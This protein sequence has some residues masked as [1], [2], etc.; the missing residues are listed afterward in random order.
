[1]SDDLTAL[2]PGGQL[3]AHVM[4]FGRLLRQLGLAV[5]PERSLAALRAMAMI[6]ITRRADF[7]WTLHAVWVHREEH[8]ALF[9]LAFRRFWQDPERAVL[10]PMLADLLSQSRVPST[11]EQRPGERRL[12]EARD[13]TQPETS[14]P[15]SPLHELAAH[16]SWSRRELLRRKDFEQMSAHEVAQAKAMVSRLRPPWRQLSTR[17]MRPVAGGRRADLRA[18]IRAS[19][20]GG[21]DHIPLRWRA[22]RHRPP[23]LVVL[24]DISGSMSTYSRMLLHFAHALSSDRDRVHTFVFATRLTNVTRTLR[25][26]DIDAALA[27]LG[28]DVPD[29]DGGTRIA[30]CLR[31]FNY[32]WSRRVLAQGAV[33]LLITDGLDRDDGE[34]LQHE[35]SRLR[36][37]CR[38]LVW[39]NP[40]LRYE[41]FEP[42]A[43]GIRAMLPHVDEMRAAHH[44]A[45]L[46]D[47]GEAL[48]RPANRFLTRTHPASRS[49]AS[50]EPRL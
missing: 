32:R 29:W 50:A 3:P 43:A 41:A 17:R 13:A 9:D 36:R 34:G 12:A 47:L 26:R 15:E 46:E 45:S 31:E 37:S 14:E 2:N 39:L 6:D 44:L 23:A 22:P 33:V 27:S 5:G 16:M 1:M 7:Y 40:L 4:G 18:T 10:D 49:K 11:A 42:R 21:G 28:R 38:Q 25:H 19:L 30:A 20:R 24:C 35:M 48:S 8:R